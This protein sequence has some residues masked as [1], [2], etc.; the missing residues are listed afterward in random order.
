MMPP[1][2]RNLRMV[3]SSSDEDDQPPPPPPLTHHQ[4]EEF[5]NNNNNISIDLQTSTIN[6][7]SVNLNSTNP[8]TQPIPLDISD[9]DE[10]IDV[11]DNLSPP[12]QNDSPPIEVGDC[13]ISGFLAGLGVRLR[14]EW[15]DSCVSGLESA[16]NGFSRLD[17]VA[18]AKLCFEQ[19][20]YSD[21][22][23]VGAGVLPGNVVDMHL[24]DL[25]GPFVLQVDEIVNISRPLKGRYQ[26]AASG[27]KR[28]LKLSMTDGV[29]RVFGMEYRPIKNLEVLAPAGMKV[30]V[31]NVNVRHGILMLVPEVL[32]VLGGHVEELE[33]ARQRLVQE[34]N[35]P[36]RGKRTKSGVVLPLETRATYAAWPRPN[37]LGAETQTN[38]SAPH[39]ATPRPNGLGAQT[40]TNISAPHIA[41]PRPNGFGAQTQTNNSAPHN[42]AP[43]QADVPG[44]TPN[45]VSINQQTREESTVRIQRQ[46]HEAN[47]SST[48]FSTL[49][50]IQ[51]VDSNTSNNVS[52]NQQSREES[53]LPIQRQV[54]E[55]NSSSTT[56]SSLDDIQVVDGNIST[57]VSINRQ[58][59]EESTI[60]LQQHDHEA[61]KS[62]T[63]F[64]SLD[65]I[66]MVD[67]EHLPVLT[68]DGE[69]PFTY[70]ASLLTK[71]AAMNGQIPNVQGKIKCFMTSVKSFQFRQRTTYELHAYVDDGSLISEILISHDLVLQAIGHPP[72]EVNAAYLSPDQK[73]V[74]DMKKTLM[75]YQ[76]FLFNFEGTMVIQISEA[77]PLPVAIEMNQ[78]CSASDA[79]GLLRRL[80]PSRSVQQSNA[81]NISP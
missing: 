37:G 47:D 65:D 31:C 29:Q 76:N 42:A 52:I 32:E 53:T 55:A 48:V 39:N 33:A 1:R 80:R 21:M 41:T 8:N 61:N 81:I 43:F 7:E 30:V 28:C 72:E 5:G 75:Q 63:A 12:E 51:M 13:A 17:D 27:H 74:D 6:F 46:Y 50:D 19:V 18:K 9:D 26:T 2:R 24:V 34:V 62:S 40:Q 49:D 20:L 35:K 68:A 58:T 70:L 56:F 54:R 10:F 57:N 44:N 15:L 38:S 60:P 79:W 78:G 64:S 25:A 16:V 71:W 73:I 77:S 11:S 23:Y 45:N 4:E 3:S 69:S 14:R 36:A 59:G 67:V 66:Q 22:N